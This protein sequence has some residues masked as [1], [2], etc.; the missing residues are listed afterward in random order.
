MCAVPP[1]KLPPF[2]GI[3]VLKEAEEKG[4]IAGKIT[5][6][7]IPTQLYIM[8]LCSIIEELREEIKQLKEDFYE[9]F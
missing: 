3:E 5:G 4:S 8:G 7:N 9:E 1:S 6:I 2:P